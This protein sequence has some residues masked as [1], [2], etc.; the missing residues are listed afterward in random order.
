M[1]HL[2]RYKNLSRVTMAIVLVIA[3]VTSLLFSSPLPIRAFELSLA[4][5]ESPITPPIEGIPTYFPGEKITIPASIVF[6]E[7]VSAIDKVELKIEG[8]EKSPG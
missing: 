6:A 2:R 3:V 4:V 1:K 5:E 7:E 8:P